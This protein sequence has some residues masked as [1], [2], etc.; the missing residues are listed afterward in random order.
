MCGAGSA[1][2]GVLLTIRN[3][4]MIRW[5]TG[6]VENC[7]FVT[8][9]E[10]LRRKRD[11][12]SI[13]LMLMV[14]YQKQ[15]SDQKPVFLLQVPQIK[16]FGAGRTVHRPFNICKV[17]HKYT[18]AKFK[19]HCVILFLK[20]GLEGLSLLETV[21]NVKPTIL[22]GGS[23]VYKCWTC[24]RSL[25]CRRS[26]LRGHAHCHGGGDADPRHLPSLQPHLPGGV[27]C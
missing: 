25:W 5:K 19:F 24:S 15:G 26:L 18:P 21:R 13:S 4:I 23:K 17:R 27:H 3:A 10:F 12:S 2:A 1:G 8:D 20:P 22:I 14:L 6:L 7:I 16:S 9:M 11:R